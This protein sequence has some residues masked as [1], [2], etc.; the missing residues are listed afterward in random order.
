[1][2]VKIPDKMQCQLSIYYA[3]PGK[4]ICI[5]QYKGKVLVFKN[6]VKNSILL[7]QRSTR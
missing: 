6:C 7:C 3:S 4:N 2:N 1:M 5:M